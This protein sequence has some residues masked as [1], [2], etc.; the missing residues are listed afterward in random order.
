MTEEKK[1]IR[2]FTEEELA[3]LSEEE[4]N[5]LLQ[6]GEVLVKAGTEEPDTP[7]EEPDGEEPPEGE[8]KPDGDEEGD[9]EVVAEPTDEELEALASDEEPKDDPIWRAERQKRQKAQKELDDT[10]RELDEVNAKMQ[11]FEKLMQEATGDGEPD[12]EDG[13]GIDFEEDMDLEEYT[14]KLLKVIEKKFSGKKEEVKEEP[15]YR[16]LHEEEMAPP[17]Y[18]DPDGND[19]SGYV[20]NGQIEFRRGKRWELV[21]DEKTG[22]SVPVF[23]AK[24]VY[25]VDTDTVD[26]FGENVFTAMWGQEGRP[27][28]LAKWRAEDFKGFLMALNDPDPP[29]A[30]FNKYLALRGKKGAPTVVTNE[31]EPH[32]FGATERGSGGARPGVKKFKTIRDVSDAELEQMSEDERNEFLLG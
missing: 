7:V 8:Q 27:G 29:K 25:E 1:G 3:A 32:G 5:E 4:R 16:T 6:S 26:R 13:L 23:D 10:R 17:R 15:G 14:E 19:Y 12:E 30:L 9:E 18:V 28:P 11:V 2:D 21:R 20:Q 22:Q 24:A 31:E